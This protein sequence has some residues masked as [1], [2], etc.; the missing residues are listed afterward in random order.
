ML[1]LYDGK[2]EEGG[3]DGGHPDEATA[4]LSMLHSPQ[5]AAANGASQGYVPV[6]AHPSEEKDAAVHVNLQE[7]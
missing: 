5:W 3:Q 6:E 4:E 2:R 1:G 7:E